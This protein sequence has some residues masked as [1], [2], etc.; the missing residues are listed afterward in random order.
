MI[1]YPET[2]SFVISYMV[3]GQIET[4]HFDGTDLP[5]QVSRG[6]VF[7]HKLLKHLC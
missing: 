2:S 5:L 1:L 3:K 6:T 4:A 7:H